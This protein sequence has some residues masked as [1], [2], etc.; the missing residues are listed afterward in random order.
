LERSDDLGEKLGDPAF[1]S[2]SEER[3]RVAASYYGDTLGL[4]SIRRRLD[5]QSCEADILALARDFFTLEKVSEILAYERRMFEESDLYTSGFSSTEGSFYA[6]LVLAQSL[7]ATVALMCIK[8]FEIE[9]AK[10]PRPG[11]SARSINFGGAGVHYRLLRGKPLEVRIWEIPE[12]GDDEDFQAAR[13]RPEIIRELT[14]GCGEELALTPFQ[15][16]EFLASSG[17]SLLLRIQLNRKLAPLAVEFDAADR[18]LTGTSAASREPSR[19]QMLATAM[20]LFGRRDAIPEVERLL[21]HP[22]HFVRWHA[23]REL[24]GMDPVAAYP[25]LLRLSRED[26]QPS[27]RRASTATLQRFFP[28]G[29]PSV[30]PSDAERSAEPACP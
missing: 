16:L 24:L 20:R 7:S 28:S 15:S 4:G 11:A 29:P 18:R 25:H 27:V 14:F 17:Y 2:R 22:L 6:G 26:P 5:E 8:P 23:M 9:L 13:M 3:S 19:L 12:F 1:W 10:K 21:T 30:E